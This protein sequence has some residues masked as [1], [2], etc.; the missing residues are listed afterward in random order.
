MKLSTFKTRN[1]AFQRAKCYIVNHTRSIFKCRFA[2]K[3]IWRSSYNKQKGSDLVCGMFMLVGA[4]K[5]I[6]GWRNDMLGPGKKKWVTP[7]MF[8]YHDF[9]QLKKK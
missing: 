6:M 4:E 3:F 1:S 2:S 9:K 5:K 7:A 8:K